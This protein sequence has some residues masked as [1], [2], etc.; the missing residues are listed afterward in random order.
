MSAARAPRPAAPVPRS[1]RGAGFVQDA[2]P[3]HV[4]VPALV[5][6]RADNVLSALGRAI[7]R[8]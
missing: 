2:L 8:L 3:P 6:E 7:R 5:A 4:V 1:S